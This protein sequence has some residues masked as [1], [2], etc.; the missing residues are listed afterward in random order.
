MILKKARTQLIPYFVL[1]LVFGLITLQL[2]RY[3]INLGS[4]INWQTMF[5]VPF[6][7]GDQF[8]LYLAAWFLLTLFFVNVLAVITYMG[9]GKFSIKRT[10]LPLI[11]ALLL[12]ITLIVTN[13]KFDSTIINFGIR[14]MLGFFFFSAGRIFRAFEPTLRKFLVKPHM[15]II[16]FVLIDIIQA[17]TGD[18]TYNLLYNDLGQ[19]RGIVIA[20]A[21]IVS[22]FSIIAII[23][24]VASFLSP[25]LTN[26]AFI[27][28]I[29]RSSFVIMVWHFTMFWIINA[30]LCIFGV[31]KFENLSDV[32]FKVYPEKTWI[33]YIA[34]GV[35]GSMG[36]GAAYQY[37]RANLKSYSKF[38][39]E[40]IMKQKNKVVFY[41]KWI[42]GTRNPT[43]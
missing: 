9:A 40:K 2:R 22:S 12:I 41:V 4:D 19:T 18:L 15:L 35:V 36:L 3:G 29:G 31:V 11:T 34:C 6:G 1:N 32:Y 43:K 24:I 21:H 17:N 38:V 5:V 37:V 16:L 13:K 14:V 25:L 23:Y 33:I 39:F 26:K 42:I 20:F 28:K 10:V 30:V 7:R 27:Y 8:Q